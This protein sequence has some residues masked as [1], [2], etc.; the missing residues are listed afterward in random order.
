MKNFINSISLLNVTEEQKNKI[1]GVHKNIIDPDEFDSVKKWISQCYNMP[2]AEEQRMCAYNEI[3][4]GYGTEAIEGPWQNGYWCNILATYVNLGDPY[5]P[6][7]IHHRSK[8]FI[9]ACWG[10][11]VELIN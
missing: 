3:L 7:I 9:I 10:D 8:G 11:I 1:I 5:I 4:E 6:T 2:S